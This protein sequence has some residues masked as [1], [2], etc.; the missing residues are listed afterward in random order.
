M[1]KKAFL[2][3]GS[4]CSIW[5]CFIFCF[6][7]IK[8]PKNEHLK[9]I[10][11]DADIA[12][13]INTQTFI[14]ALTYDLLI[15]KKDEITIARLQAFIRKT[16]DNKTGIDFSKQ[17]GIF[18]KKRNEKH[19]VVCLLKLNDDDLFKKFMKKNSSE[20]TSCIVKEGVGYIG[21]TISGRI[22]H[23]MLKRYLDGLTKSDNS[24]EQ[25]RLTDSTLAYLFY[26][27]NNR[28]KLQITLK[29]EAIQF[30]GKM[31]N[32]NEPRFTAKNSIAPHD[33]HITA[34]IPHYLSSYIT[35][36]LNKTD[37]SLPELKTLSLNYKQTNILQKTDGRLIIQPVFS[38][39][40]SFDSPFFS[41]VL[42]KN[43]ASRNGIVLTQD[44]FNIGNKLYFIDSLSP[45]D[46][47]IGTD[48]THLLKK[49]SPYSFELKGEPKQLKKINCPRYLRSILEMLP[50]FS[51]PNEFLSELEKIN[52]TIDKSGEIKGEIRF[53][54]NH[55]PS[56]AITKLFLGLKGL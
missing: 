20:N 26:P 55:S 8:S 34:T 16:E 31:P 46:L 4:I 35:Q 3:L 48:R 18:S 33:F 24:T 17:I 25:E 28:Y 13:V 49:D 45:Q 41:A 15:S 54:K 50:V 23:K 22:D 37:I 56:I 36:L 14:N 10:P 12:G 51:A 29:N 2:V 9:L 27:K 53:K 5:L 32:I 1:T 11:E 42:K 40:F 7:F 38:A 30:L 21:T 43:I 52:L 19:Y 47:F 39:L 44:G 6:F